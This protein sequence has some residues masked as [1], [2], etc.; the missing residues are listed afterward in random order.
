MDDAHGVFDRDELRAIGLAVDFGAGEARQDDRPL[1]ANQVP[2]VELGAH[3]DDHVAVLECVRGAV[4]I[5]RCLEE[6]A[7]HREEDLRAAV[8]HRVNRLDCIE[9]VRTRRVEPEDGL[10]SIEQRLL[11]AVVNPH[12]P[13]ALNVA[14]PTHRTGAGPGHSDAAAH[15]EEV[16]DLADVAD[17][18]PVLGQAHRPAD[19]RSSAPQ[20]DL[21]GLF[22]LTPRDARGLDE[23]VDV[24]RFEVR[25]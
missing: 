23:R 21:D 12:R 5:G 24:L 25:S 9:A 11:W 17:S 19:N 10:D 3:V 15:Q 1:A 13:V 7:S 14:V 16:D 6:V 4:G 22:E 18:V 2:T 20:H 8:E